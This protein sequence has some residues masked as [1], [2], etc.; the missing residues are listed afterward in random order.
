MCMVSLIQAVVCAKDSE[1][2]LAILQL[3]KVVIILYFIIDLHSKVKLFFYL[4]AF[5]A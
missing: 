3:I 2:S 1:N 5:L 4:N